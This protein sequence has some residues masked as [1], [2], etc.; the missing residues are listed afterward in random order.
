MIK[1]F[2]TFP[3][4]SFRFLQSNQNDILGVLD[5]EHAEN[6]TQIKLMSK[7]AEWLESQVKDSESVLKE[8]MSKLRQS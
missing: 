5:L 8:L 1:E 7:K 3:I 6:T 2:N 4:N